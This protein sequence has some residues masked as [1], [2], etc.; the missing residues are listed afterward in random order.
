MKKD[1]A[2][3]RKY[4]AANK[5]LPPSKKGETR[6]VFM[7]DSITEFWESIDKTFFQD[8]PYINRGI[9]G[10]TTPQVLVRFRPDVIALKPSL[11]VILTGINDIAQ[12]TGP[13]EPEETLGNIVS[14]TELA[15]TNNINV[16][17]CSILPAYDFNWRPGLQPA[18]KIIKL[19]SMIKQYCRKNKITYVD[20]Y[21]SLVDKRKGLDKKFTGD[22]VHPVLSGYKVMGSLVERGI[23]RELLYQNKTL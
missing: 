10:Q 13:M 12:N 21:S 18:Q 14:M 16:V 1:W 8:K 11:V 2:N 5:K 15:R 23:K 3:L 6:I 22:G 7:G 19:N 20:Y 9:R 17:L 4:S